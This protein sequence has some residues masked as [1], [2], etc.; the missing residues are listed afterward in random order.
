[1]EHA[2]DAIGDVRA[3]A[4]CFFELKSRGII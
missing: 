1:M 4:K 2:H 3:T